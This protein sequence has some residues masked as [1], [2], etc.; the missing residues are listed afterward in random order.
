MGRLFGTDGV[1]GIANESLTCE[2]AMQLGAAGAHILTNEVHSPRVLVAMDTRKSGKMLSSALCAGICSVGGD[3]I[4]LGVLPTPA[5]SCLVQLYE[6][7]AAVMIS[8]SHNSM[9]YNGIK[10]FDGTGNKLSD[11][12]EDKIEEVIMGSKLLPRPVGGDV[13]RITRMRRAQDDYM[14]FLVN[15][16][17]TRLDGLKLVLDCANGAAS[18]IARDVFAGLGA[19]VLSFSDEPDG[20]NINDQC[21]STHPARMQQLVGELGADVGL[22]FDGDADRLIAADERG[23]LVDGDRIMGI[24]ALDMH[25][26]GALKEDT[27]VLTVMSNLGLKQRMKAA[28]IRLEETAV[29]DRYVL[30]CMK[31]H[32]YN[33]GGEQSGHIIFSD[34]H[35]TGDGMLSAIQLLGVLKQSGKRMSTLAM[36]IPIYPQ[37]LANVRVS[38]AAKAPAM[39]DEALWARVREL[40]DTL[41]EDGRVLVRASGTEPLIRIMLEGKDEEAIQEYAIELAKILEKNHGGKLKG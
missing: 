23:R 34:Y 2:L 29:G 32:G 36:E 39:A 16:S 3:V 25:A 30:E 17:P 37:V 35:N 14:E 21:G 12:L 5:L 38:E 1:R 4:Q 18:R 40:E 31:Q 15:T 6:A 7:D 11:A 19:T 22:A 28:G 13:G 10:W 27:L 9:E 26:R 20:Y 41:G 8:A 24:C 33:L